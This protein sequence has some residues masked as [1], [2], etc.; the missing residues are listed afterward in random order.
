MFPQVR[1]YINVSVDQ[2]LY[3]CTLL[4][5]YYN[6]YVDPFDCDS[7]PCHLAWLLRDNRNLLTKLFNSAR[8]SDGR[9]FEP[10]SLFAD[11]P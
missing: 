6:L 1:N 11:C 4:N 9:Y 7:D 5:Y 3:A 8:C 10:A 2:K